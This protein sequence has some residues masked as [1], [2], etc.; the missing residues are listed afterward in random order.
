MTDP[1]PRLQILTADLGGGTGNHLLGL[2]REPA[3]AGFAARIL[4]E[5]PLTAREEPPVPLDRMPDTRLRYPLAQLSRWR[6][7]R[8]ELARSRPDLVHAYF[9][10]PIIYAR[11]LRRAGIIRAL[12]ENREDQ[13]FAW[14][15]QE[16]AL[17]RATRHLPDRVICVSEAVRRV[18]LER[19]GLD[20]TRVVTIRNGI[21]AELPAEEPLE[22]LRTELGLRPDDLVLGVVANF[23]RAVKGMGHLI[24]AVPLILREVPNARVL[25][26]GR[27]EEEG[28]LRERCRALGVA[29]AVIFG[30]F[31]RDMHRCYRLM[32]VSGLTSLSEG[33]SITVLESMKFGV[34]VVATAVGGNPE[35]VSDGVT[36]IL[37]PPA[38][39]AAFSRAVV[40]LLRDPVGREAMGRAARARIE[41]EFALSG[42]AGRYAA[43]YREVLAERLGI[44]GE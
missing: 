26:L 44:N 24:E 9:F 11:L 34:P 25:L 6:W 42:V 23:N 14:G 2:L 35:V 21:D 28:A 36:G 19:E 20:P 5:R 37:V 27:G 18:V 43:L 12:V 15:R 33:L 40:G 1:R 41:R 13:G 29:D 10:W 22:E 8:R 3:L 32:H 31:R 7:L 4:S 16:Y 38:D 39:P 17:L 30:G